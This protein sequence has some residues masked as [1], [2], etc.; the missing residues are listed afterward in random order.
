MFISLINYLLLL[1]GV[2]ISFFLIES[3]Q[4]MFKTVQCSA[5]QC[6]AVQ[7]SALQYS[8]VQYSTVQYSTVQ[9]PNNHLRPMPEERVWEP[10]FYMQKKMSFYKMKI[11]NY[12]IN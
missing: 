8:T 3:I 1:K 10:L 11:S 4:F 9:Y 5:V 12:Q 2:W 7:C 6:S